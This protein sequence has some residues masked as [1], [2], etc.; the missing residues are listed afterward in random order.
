MQNYSIHLPVLTLKAEDDT[1]PLF[2]PFR[3]WKMNAFFRSFKEAENH[4][5]TL[6]LS[7]PN[8]MIEPEREP[9]FR[10]SEGFSE[11][12][13]HRLDEGQFLF[14]TRKTDGNHV[15][16]QY[17]YD[18]GMEEITVTADRTD[19]AGIAVIEGL[20]RILP[21]LLAKAQSILLHGVLM[22]HD[23]RGIIL[24]A[25][26]GTGKSTHAHLW[27][28]CKNA[29]I[30]DG[31]LSACYRKKTGQE[32]VW[33]GFGMPWCGTSGEYINREVPVTAI[34]VL[35]QSDRNMVCRLKGIEA[36]GALVPQLQRPVWDRQLAEAAVDMMTDMLE[37]IP[38]FR[39][40]CRPDEEA[41]EVLDQ[42]LREL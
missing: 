17:L 41:A 10:T 26:S 23:G 15:Y 40:A 6:R 14:T 33:T 28:S 21:G 30:L 4:V 12:L 38:V 36:F 24:S 11:F 29:L 8:G 31:D 35:E 7:S 22:E 39:L 20:V 37:R 16:L 3:Q 13:I 42:A 5:T 19:T 32:S 1:Y 18:P 34:V 2:F 9:V 27:Q 25:P